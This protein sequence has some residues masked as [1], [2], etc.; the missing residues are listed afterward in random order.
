MCRIL[1]QSEIL[2][3]QNCPSLIFYYFQKLGLNPSVTKDDISLLS[4]HPP[5]RKYRVTD[6]HDGV[7]IYF[8]DHIHF[9]RRADLAPIEIEC[10]WIE[11]AFRHNHI[12]F[13]LFY[14]PPSSDV[15]VD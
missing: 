3:W 2:S 13:A 8:K 7:I 1:F 6:S 9:V 15:L 14:R 5:E 4:Y 11:L 10:V 12:L